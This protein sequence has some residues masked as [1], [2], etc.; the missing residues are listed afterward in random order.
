MK[1]IIILMSSVV[2][3][4]SD[5]PVEHESCGSYFP[6]LSDFLIARNYLQRSDFTIH[7]SRKK[8]GALSNRTSFIKD[9]ANFQYHQLASMVKKIGS[10]IPLKKTGHRMLIMT[11][12]HTF[13]SEWP[14]E[15]LALFTSQFPIFYYSSNMNSSA[16]RMVPKSKVSLL[17][18]VYLVMFT[19]PSPCSWCRP[20]FSRYRLA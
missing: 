12:D 10:M 5:P 11:F 3:V 20:F 4:L 6:P 7:I 19:Q 13:P 16:M 9:Q 1:S 18:G 2:I 14:A 8:Y 15:Q 17:S